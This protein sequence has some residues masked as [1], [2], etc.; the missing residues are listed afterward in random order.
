LPIITVSILEKI[1]PDIHQ[2]IT[3]FNAGLLPNMVQLK[4]KLMAQ[5]IFAFYRGTCHLFYEDLAAAKPL[6]PSPVTWLCGDLHLENFGSYKADNRMVYFDLNDF[7]EGI[8]APA[9]WELARMVTSIFIAFENPEMDQEVAAQF[10]NNYSATLIKGKAL[11]LD[12]RIAK[13]I[14]CTFLTAVEKRKQKDL[15]KRRTIAKKNKLALSIDHEKYFELDK[16]LKKQLAKHINE[17]IKTY[18]DDPYDFEVVDGIFRLAGTGSVGV[19]RYL[20]LLKSLNTKNKYLLLDMKQARASSLKPYV[21]IKQPQWGTEADRVIAVKQ[22][23]Q[24]VSPALLGSTV[25]NGDPYIL[26]EMQPTADR[27]NF[28]LIKD[29][30]NDINQVIH[31]MAMLTASAQLRSSGRQGSAIADELITFGQHTGWHKDILNYAI[32]YAKQV[33]LDYQEYVKGYN[34]GK[35]KRM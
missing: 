9:A 23:M 14:V 21:K 2:R 19:K 15:L 33:K 17:L 16:P 7:D 32:K 27:I 6:P 5:N 18:N 25:F 20:L 1:M 26:Q 12:P 30:Q 13:G 34:E 31:D 11:G 29:R 28:E 10:L 35:Y 8:L 22:R 24:N 4:Y 3:A